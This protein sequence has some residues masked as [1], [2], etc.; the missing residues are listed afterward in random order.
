M[1]SLPKETSHKRDLPN[2]FEGNKANDQQ[3]ATTTFKNW[4]AEVQIYISLEDHNLATIMEDTKNLKL[5]IVDEHYIDYVLHQQGMGQQDEDDIRDREVERM[6]RD[7]AR[8]V[9]APILRR[10]AE[11]ARRR[12]DNEDG[13]LADEAVPRVHDLPQGYDLL[14]DA[15]RHVNEFKEAFN[16]YNRVLQYVLTKTTQG[17]VYRL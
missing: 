11:L 7:H 6:T 10:T 3:G 9:T 2:T 16:H 5:A 4:A 13:I 1:L 14:T 12:R 15:Q 17:E 8:D